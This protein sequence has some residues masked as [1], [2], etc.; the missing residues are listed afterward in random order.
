MFQRIVAAFDGSEW[1]R[2]AVR[3][4]GEIS[5]SQSG[6]EVWIVCAMGVVPSSI[7]ETIA[8]QWIADQTLLGN[9]LMDE[10]QELLGEGA[11]LHR[12]LLFGPPAES[13]IEVA[14]A[15]NS[16][17]IVMGSRGLGALRGLLLGSQSH[18]VI[19]LANCP[20]LVVK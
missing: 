2:R 1:S 15:R 4:A 11:I 5:H 7:G 18:K 13:I 20:V 14:E 10:A 8:E 19:N 12:E 9:K 3:L 6:T 16:D 17:L